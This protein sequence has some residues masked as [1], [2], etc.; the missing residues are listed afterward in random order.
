MRAVATMGVLAGGV[1]LGFRH[2]PRAAATGRGSFSHA[3]SGAALEEGYEVKDLSAR[4]LAGAL[5]ALAVCAAVLVGVVFLLI[6]WFGHL[7]A[8]RDVGL[9]SEQTAVLTP[10]GPQLQR[11]PAGDLARE[12][13]RE[14]ALLQGY[15]W[16]DAGHTRAHVPIERARALVIGQSLEPAP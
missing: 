11:D 13:A 9:T 14:A 10:P 2:A 5:S 8:A 4:G 15:A 7:D 1:M 3:P 12:R 16:L 6:A